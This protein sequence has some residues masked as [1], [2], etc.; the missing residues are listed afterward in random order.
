MCWYT[1]T[2]DVFASLQTRTN[3]KYFHVPFEFRQIM[4]K[5][6]NDERACFNLIEEVGYD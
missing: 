6:N 1:A 3:N 4:I 2:E 5:F